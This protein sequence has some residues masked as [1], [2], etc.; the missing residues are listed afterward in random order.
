MSSSEVVIQLS[1][2]DIHQG[3]NVVLHDVNISIHA[4]EFIY[5]IGRTGSG[6][7]SLLKTLY[8]DLPLK[9]GTGEC[10]GFDL[11]KLKTREI[12]YLRRKLGIVFQD[13]ELLTDRSVH[14]NLEFVLRATGWTD[15]RAMESRIQSVLDLVQL[16]GKQQKFTH[17]LSGGEQQRVAIARALL[18]TPHLILADEPTGNLDPQ[19]SLEILNLLLAISQAGTTVL[20]ASHDYA[21]MQKFSS[22]IILCDNGS[23]KEMTEIHAS[24]Q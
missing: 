5:L 21:T 10:C 14:D 13:F 3:G 18:N 11:Q 23:V 17:E 1:N 22:R 2:A 15:K 4:G 24:V 16:E 8:G 19:T 20:M 7:S 12:P 6:K 9:K